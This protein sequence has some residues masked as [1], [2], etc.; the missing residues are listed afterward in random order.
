MIYSR[1]VTKRRICN[2]LFWIK[3]SGADEEVFVVVSRCISCCCL[4]R[5]DCIEYWQILLIMSTQT[6][7]FFK[8]SF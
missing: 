2:K 4:E 8:V 5:K 6:C 7:V 3:L 1:V